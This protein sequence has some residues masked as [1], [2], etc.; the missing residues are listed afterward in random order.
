MKLVL[1][2]LAAYLLGSLPFGYLIA[3]AN[4]GLDIRQIGSGGAG[5]T[6]VARGAGKIAGVLTLLLDALKGA[7]AVWLARRIQ[8]SLDTTD[9]IVAAAAVAVIVGHIFPV[10]LS[11]PGGKGV[12]T[13]ATLRPSV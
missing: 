3:L 7:A 6:N 10:W 13:R 11:V 4:T 8:G 1:V 12:Y 2:V 5:A 9:W